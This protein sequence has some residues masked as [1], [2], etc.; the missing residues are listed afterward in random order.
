MTYQDPKLPD[1]VLGRNPPRYGDL[2]TDAFSTGS[3][4]ALIFGTV[5]IGCVIFSALSER[6][7]TANSPPIT[8]GQGGERVSPPTAPRMVPAAPSSTV[9]PIDQNVPAEKV[10]PPIPAEPRTNN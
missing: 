6:S 7:T 1:P 9:P 4:I 2:D 10:A 8:T 3:I 5:L